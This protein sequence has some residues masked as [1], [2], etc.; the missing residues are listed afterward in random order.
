MNIC[1]SRAIT[2]QADEFGFLYPQLTGTCAGCGKCDSIC[3]VQMGEN[4]K[5]DCTE[6]YAAY[7]KD[8]TIRADS[9]SGGVF[10]LLALDVLERG[11]A[12]YGAAFD[13]R[14]AIKH[15][16]V[17]KV[18]ELSR[19]RGAKY[20]QS[21][22]AECFREIREGL[23][24][25][26][27]ILFSGTPCQA[28]GLHSFLGKEY[29]TLLLVDT[30]CHSVPSPA[31]WLQY[32]KYRADCDNG[33]ALPKHINQRSKR[34]GWSRYA[35]SSL[36]E[37]ENG[38]TYCAS[39]SD[40]LY[41]KLFVGGYLSRESCASCRFKGLDRIS[42]ITLGD[43]WGIWDICPEF[44]DNKG[45]SLLLVHSEKG[46]KAIEALTSGAMKSTRVALESAY[47]E[48]QAII[49]PYKPSEKRDEAL[50]ACVAG[51]FGACQKILNPS[52]ASLFR[53]I[54]RKIK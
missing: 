34:S 20:A 46:K 42:D 11:G 30:V 27:Q 1:D 18:S 52:K 32:V 6:A 29:D 19:L 16:C 17:E 25:G 36:F 2:M 13:E 12:V 31:A 5:P 43:F 9:S 48:N 8:E 50:A 49:K 39:P 54:M 40:D 21:D 14:F 53:R 33:G 37:Y 15:I 45:T 7:A 35:Y 51:D 47:A 10:S 24:R 44:D 38:T 41:R 28:A 3:P 23:E 26:Q 4:G 22:V